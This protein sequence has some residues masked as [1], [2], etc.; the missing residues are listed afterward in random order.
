M[1]NILEE[2]KREPQREQDERREPDIDQEDKREPKREHTEEQGCNISQYATQ[3][4]IFTTFS[5]TKLLY[6]SVGSYVP[7][8]ITSRNNKQYIFLSF[9]S[10]YCLFDFVMV[11]DDFNFSSLFAFIH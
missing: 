3:N 9:C 1:D 7:D 4:N 10:N 11:F 5:K 8:L 2:V 6:I